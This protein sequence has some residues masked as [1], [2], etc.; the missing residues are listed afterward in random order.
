MRI[1]K[2]EVSNFLRIRSV[3][4][5]PAGNVVRL[6]GKN[7]QGKTSILR[8]IQA[9]LGGAK[10]KPKRPI[11]DGE[12]E[13]CVRIDLGEYL[14]EVLFKAE[15]RVDLTLRTAD[16]A[17]VRSP[18]TT[19]AGFVGMI[20]FDALAF[21]RLEP[22]AQVELLRKLAG[23]DFTALEAERAT[24]YGKRTEVGRDRDKAL[25]QAAGAPHGDPPAEVSLADLTAQLQAVSDAETEE[26]IAADTSSRATAAAR[27][28]GETVARLQRELAAAEIAWT[29]AKDTD[30]L[31]ESERTEARRRREAM[32]DGAAIRTKL[33]TAEADN[34]RARDLAAKRAKKLEG[35]ALHT[36]YDALT[37][38]IDGI[39]DRKRKM[40]AAAKL[41]VDGLDFTGAEVTFG[42]R[43]ISQASDREQVLISAAIGHAL[44]PK[45]E[46][47][48]IREGA[49]LD[50]DGWKALAEWAEERD[51]QVWIEDVGTDGAGILIEDGMVVEGDPAAE[52]QN[53]LE[54]RFE[55][56]PDFDKAKGRPRNE[57]PSAVSEAEAMLL[58]DDDDEEEN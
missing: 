38:T 23:V 44:N 35:D 20:S 11:R 57:G 39:D 31:R 25:A 3:T 30:K 40:V 26:R 43:P 19:L 54:A 18:A 49:F 53:K 56:R 50:E 27:A 47:L 14:V 36:Q 15:G 5:V 55:A 51:V 13:A 4:I 46:A 12:E 52:L 45:L 9:A 29:T 2:L 58:G 22:A 21:M 33:V 34:A 1:Q 7:R 32:G 42:G 37:K 48:L 41:P 28:A 6:K 17:P 8:A 16:G 10:M 24:H